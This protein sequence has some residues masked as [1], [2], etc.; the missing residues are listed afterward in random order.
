MHTN[1]IGQ[2]NA[3]RKIVSPVSIFHRDDKH[4]QYVPKAVTIPD[5]Y[6]ASEDDGFF[7]QRTFWRELALS[8]P[9]EDIQQLIA[10]RAAEHMASWG[11]V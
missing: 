4:S 2:T 6:G 11:D 1:S 8:V 7:D 5:A 9:D 3:T 10:D